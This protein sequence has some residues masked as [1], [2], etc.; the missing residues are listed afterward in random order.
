MKMNKFHLL[1]PVESHFTKLY[2]IFYVVCTHENI[3]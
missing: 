2:L 1:V 3:I